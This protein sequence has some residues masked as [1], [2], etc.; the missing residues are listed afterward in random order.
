MADMR[1]LEEEAER[2]NPVNPKK[3]L[4]SRKG[5]VGIL[6]EPA[7]VVRGAGA[8]P[9]MG[10][11]TVRGGGLLG[12]DGHGQ[13][14]VGAGYEDSDS[15]MEGCGT[16]K[17][18]MR[19]TARKAYEDVG[20]RSI[21][22]H[23]AEHRALEGGAAHGQLLAQRMME[24]HGKGFFDDFAKGFMSVAKPLASVAK[25]AL[26]FVAPGMAGT[27]A[28][29]VLGA[30]GAGMSGGGKMEDAVA[31]IVAAL[32]NGR[33]M[34][35]KLAEEVRQRHGLTKA[36]IQKA[37]AKAKQFKE[38]VDMG[39]AGVSLM[40]M[41]RDNPE[42]VAPSVVLAKMKSGKGVMSGGL[43]TGAYEGKGFLSDLGIPV[44]SDLA[45]AVGLGKKKRAPAGAS[46]KRKARGAMV[47]KL[48]R[49]E[50]MSLAEA[51]RHIK[52]HGM[53]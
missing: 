20:R 14:M 16:R 23:K 39:A 32:S 12:Q 29:G 42:G 45:R 11:S 50:G 5:Y 53:A 35:A 6:R 44:V 49:E 41:K 43:G 7:V 15:D 31:D 2:M 10:L 9:S 25:V 30:L 37:G 19:K 13:R 40:G 48:M 1:A 36:E 47:S 46:D 52:A 33:S 27:V 24:L 28:S 17:G 3:Q 38:D 34:D 21:A 22:L 8:T 51:S 18:M 4:G 26:P